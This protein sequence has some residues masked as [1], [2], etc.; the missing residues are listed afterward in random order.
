MNGIAQ[1]RADGLELARDVHLQLP[2]L[3]D[4]RPRD[5]E[6]RAIEADVETAEVHVS[7]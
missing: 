7:G 4:A 2:R 3:D 1:R 6:Q 5:Q